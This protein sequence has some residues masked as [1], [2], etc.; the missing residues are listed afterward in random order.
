MEQ[1][2]QGSS[3][4]TVLIVR[5]P[6]H[7]D[8]RREV[9]LVQR[10][11]PVR[12]GRHP[13][14]GLHLPHGWVSQWHGVISF[15]E[16]RIQFLHTG[17]TNRT[18]V[19][20]QEIG[21]GQSVELGRKGELKIGPMVVLLEIQ[22]QEVDEPRHTR[23]R[24]LPRPGI[25]T[26]AEAGPEAE[27]LEGS[28]RLFQAMAKLRPGCLAYQDA[29]KAIRASLVS[30]SS[31]LDPADREGLFASV[32]AGFPE[33]ARHPDFAAL[34]AE[35]GV[36]GTGS[37]SQV[38][39]DLMLNL[40][41]VYA[42]PAEPP[43]TAPELEDF[44][45]QVAATLE[46]LGQGFVEGRNTYMKV[47]EGLGLVVSDP[48]N[49]LYQAH[50]EQDVLRHVLRWR[51]QGTAQALDELRALTADVG[52]HQLAMLEAVQAGVQALLAYL[53]PDEIEVEIGPGPLRVASRWKRYQ[54]R[55]SH[56]MESQT[57]QRDILF[58]N[59][60]KRAYYQTVYSARG[61]SG[62][63]PSPVA[64]ASRTQ[65]APEDIKPNGW[66][67]EETTDFGSVE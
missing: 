19:A 36:A 62:E 16:E 29:W 6:D 35:Q 50:A 28:A 37:P 27:T 24:F 18:V 48:R 15:D 4:L 31:G 33:I 49:T 42:S 5:F 1:S 3:S 45:H 8:S 2:R 47:V 52:L 59:E 64:V 26:G 51:G 23:S 53:S 17:R 34:A 67:E 38:A 30:A 13:L 10:R 22:P 39:L 14:N 65:V 40:A 63:R 61:H 57:H 32:M 21:H 7:D 44:M 41:E 20:G 54:E 46:I 11:S 43:E 60:F 12:I 9:R 58:G 66:Q 56:L 25:P 55:H